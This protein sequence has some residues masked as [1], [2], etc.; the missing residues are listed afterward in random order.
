ML[1]LK[2]IRENPEIVRKAIRDKRATVDLDAFLALDARRR[3]LIGKVESARAEQNK[4]TQQISVMKK[5][6]QDASAVIAEMGRLSD[7]IRVMNDE[8]RRVEAELYELHIRIPN[9]PHESVPVGTEKDNVVVKQWGELPK[10]DFKPLPHWEIAEK[11]GLIDFARASRMSGSFFVSYRGLGAKLERALINFMIDLHVGKHG[12]TEVF[13][14]FVVKR[15]AMFGTGQLPK[16]EEDMYRCELDDLFLIPTAEVPVTNLHREEVLEGDELPIK[17]TAYTPCFRREAGAYGKDTRGLMRIHQFDKVEMVKFVKP[18]TSWD[19]LESLLRDAEEVLQLLE[20][21]YR[22]VTLATGDLSFSAAK[23]YD[24]EVYAAGLDRWLEV[25]SCSNFT[26]FQ[27]RR[28][29]IRFRRE[30][31]AKP[32]YV[33]TLNGSGIALPRTVIAILENYQTDEGRVIVPKV[34]RPYMG[35]DLI[36]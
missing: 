1:D 35:V 24:I 25:S 6:G 22:V 12:Y 29:N 13:P 11:L 14:P 5:A 7:E 23:C 28:A 31:G 8:L 10:L 9:I 32:E 15:E 17:Y 34:L 16:L 19:E 20:L 4:V 18:E 2:F 21:P 3:E 33:H 26:D 36:K 30:K 27:A